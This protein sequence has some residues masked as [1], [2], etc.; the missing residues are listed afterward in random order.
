[1]GS[2][3]GSLLAW[4]RTSL[5]GVP[6]RYSRMRSIVGPLGIAVEVILTATS[7]AFLLVCMGGHLFLRLAFARMISNRRWR[8]SGR[9]ATFSNGH[10]GSGSWLGMSITFGAAMAVTL[11]LVKTEHVGEREFCS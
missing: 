11:R 4:V 8:N 10:C 7:I 2:G 3:T 1:M 9:E 6:W 5:T